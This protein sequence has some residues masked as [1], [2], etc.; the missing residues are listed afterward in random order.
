M[1]SLDHC[2][3]KFCPNHRVIS[4]DNALWL[5]QILLSSCGQG[6][7]PVV[8]F[9]LKCESGICIVNAVN[10]VVDG[11]SH[12]MEKSAVILPQLMELFTH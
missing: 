10:V 6:Y 5:G 8:S 1:C 3:I 4:I 11:S 7:I 9:D 12:L 2:N